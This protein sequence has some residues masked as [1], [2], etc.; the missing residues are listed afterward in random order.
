L[1]SAITRIFQIVSVNFVNQRYGA[2][3]EADNK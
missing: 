1:I 3:H 2:E